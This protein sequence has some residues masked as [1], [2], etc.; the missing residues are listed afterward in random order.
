MASRDFILC[1]KVDEANEESASAEE[2]KDDAVPGTSCV[3][4]L[5]KCP[6]TVINRLLISFPLIQEKQTV[7]KDL[8]CYKLLFVNMYE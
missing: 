8:L 6:C 4:A 5:H 1:P 3:A 2:K 7:T